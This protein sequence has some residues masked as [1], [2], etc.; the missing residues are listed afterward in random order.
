MSI[1]GDGDENLRFTTSIFS[2]RQPTVC[3][4]EWIRVHYGPIAARIEPY[5]GYDFLQGFFL[6]STTR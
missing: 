2:G 3:Q 1:Q 5:P 4:Q 6:P